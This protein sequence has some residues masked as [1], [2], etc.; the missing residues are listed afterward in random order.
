MRFWRGISFMA[1]LSSLRGPVVL[2]K[3]CRREAHDQSS[4]CPAADALV[5][6]H[7]C[8]DA[9]FARGKARALNHIAALDELRALLLWCKE[10]CPAERVVAG[11]R[12]NLILHDVADILSRIQA[13]VS[14]HPHSA[15]LSAVEHLGVLT[16]RVGDAPPARIGPCAD[17]NELC[18]RLSIT[19]ALARRVAERVGAADISFT[20]KTF[21]RR[22]PRLLHALERSACA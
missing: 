7:G 11:H 2:K 15:P 13:E 19:R 12:A 9:S 1:G 10:S 3:K 20:S 8:M 6:Y 17:R 16:S 22:V 14:G 4:V 18:A 5:C 21:V